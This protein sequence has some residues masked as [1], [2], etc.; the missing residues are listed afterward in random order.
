MELL[1]KYSSVKKYVFLMFGLT[2]LI[3]LCLSNVSAYQVKYYG[4]VN[5][6]NI[7]SF[8]IPDKYF[9]GIKVI[10]INEKCIYLPN[11][12]MIGAW[13]QP[14][15]IDMFCYNANKKNLIHE[16]SHHQQF[17][18]ND[19]LGHDKQFYIYEDEITYAT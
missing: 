10:R 17:I 11:D 12:K 16:L 7:S 3:T 1:Y 19:K 15:V 4:K 9:D 5:L 6:V 18:N 8:N 13:Y 2:L 14:N